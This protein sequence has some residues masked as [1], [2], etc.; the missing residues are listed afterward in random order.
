MAGDVDLPSSQQA[1]RVTLGA[2]YCPSGR[3]NPGKSF[4]SA[5]RAREGDVAEAVLIIADDCKAAGRPFLLGTDANAIV[6]PEDTF[7]S[8]AT[9]R[10]ASCINRCLAAGFPDPFRFLHP[11]MQVASHYAT[12]GW[13]ASRLDYILATAIQHLVPVGAAIHVGAVWP[14]DHH[15]VLTDFWAISAP[16]PA[17][18]GSFR[19]KWRRFLA[20]AEEAEAKAEDKTRFENQIQEA[21]PYAVPAAGPSPDGVVQRLEQ[22]AAEA[23]DTRSSADS[24]SAS[25]L[26]P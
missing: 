10:E 26:W 22:W 1:T 2:A 3:T 9:P 6:S 18:E 15:P 17:Q 13:S 5:F 25:T 8:T 7:D 4:S 12:G 21:L 24:S 11:G 20:M 14:Y 19:L 16:A 23:S